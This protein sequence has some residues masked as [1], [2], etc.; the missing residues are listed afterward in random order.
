[1]RTW[2]DGYHLFPREMLCNLK[3]DPWEQHDLAAERPEICAEGA[4][5]YAAWH[6]DMMATQPEGYTVDPMQIVLEEGGPLHAR[7]YLAAYIP[8]LE[9]TGRGWAVEEL[10]R[11]H[12]DEK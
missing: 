1:M 8:Y 3:D 12:P 11:R 2:H 10:K 9:Q 7:G 5:R 4:R 6:D